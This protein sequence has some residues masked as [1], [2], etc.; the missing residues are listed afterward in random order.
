MITFDSPLSLFTT[1]FGWQFYNVIWEALV[2][3]GIA[4]LPF[5]GLLIN[6]VIDTR[7]EGDLTDSQSKVA[8]ARLETQL[9][10]MLIVIGF[11]GTPTD[12]TS[13]QHDN[14]QARPYAKTISDPAPATVTPAASDS[15]YDA[16]FG[17]PAGDASCTGTDIP[18][19][20]WWY[21]VVAFS[22]GFN[23]AVIAGLPELEGLRDVIA[24]SKLAN[25]ADPAVQ[26]ETNMFYSQC[27]TPARSKLQESRPA[28]FDPRE[29]WL[30]SAT[31]LAQNRF[32]RRDLRAR[33]AIEGFP[34]DASRDFEWETAPADGWGKPTCRQWW[35]GE[36]AAAGA[37]GLRAKLIDEVNATAA[38]LIPAI[39]AAFPGW[40]TP[41]AVDNF[42]VRKLIENNPPSFSNEDLLLS[43]NNYAGVG[44]TMRT[45]AREIGLGSGR[46]DVLTKLETMLLAA[47]MLQALI[48]LGIF[49]LLPFLLVASRYSLSTLIVGAVAIFTVSSWSSWWYMASWVDENLMKSF[50]PDVNY[51][52]TLFSTHYNTNTG[53]LISPVGGTTKFN[54]LNLA[55]AS[56]YVF[57]PLIFSTLMGLAGYQAARAASTLQVAASA[58]AVNTAATGAF[59]A[60]KKVGGKVATVGRA[61]LAKI[62]K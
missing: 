2:G 21:G 22:E 11:A 49:G 57:F 3:T 19:P 29:L 50:W 6:T 27:F 55:T 34:Y 12:L 4:F 13:F 18:V 53:G 24:T 54:L 20:A 39:A 56:T 58:P 14:I 30:G 5:L 45:A 8:L 23:R 40:A 37:Q 10:V 41:G 61:S 32:Y 43:R 51:L 15:T 38:G 31:F 16:V 1:L 36:G 46:Q 35:L 33:V 7:T 59:N 9:L 52:D 26:A 48:K 60:G 17:C 25:I 42:A 47:P 44:G 28:A 62:G